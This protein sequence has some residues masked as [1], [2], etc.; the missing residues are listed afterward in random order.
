M[1]VTRPNIL[2]NDT[3]LKQYCDGV[4]LL[5]NEFTGPTSR[6]LGI[7][8]PSRKVST[9][10]LFVIWHVRAMMTM[11]PPN[12]SQRNAA[13]SGPVFLP[14]HRFMLRQLELNLQRILSNP[15]F[16]LPYWDWAADG[17]MP[18]DQQPQGPLWSSDALGGTGSPVSDGP[19]VFK[20]SDPTS[21]RVLIETDSNGNLRQTSRGLN[22][23]LGEEDVPG[24]PTKGDTA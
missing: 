21:F 15:N 12:Q 17:E 1:A 22:R 23:T 20:T 14:W 7:S 9:Y 2:T 8:G 6:S 3:A 19:F 11:T 18:Q 10:D 13:H 16:G 24:L 4:K 5:K